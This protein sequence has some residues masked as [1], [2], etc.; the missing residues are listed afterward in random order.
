MNTEEIFINADELPQP[1]S[2]EKLY[3]LV[4]EAHEGSKESMNKLITHNILLVLYEVRNKFRTVNYDK[5]E[6]VSIG[7]FGLIKAVNTFDLSRKFKFSSYAVK[8]IDNE[9]LQFLKKLKRNQ[10]IDSLDE[11]IYRNEN[12]TERKLKDKLSDNND[13][14]EN[15]EKEETNRIIRKVVEKL[16][17]LEREIIMLSFGFYDYKIYTQSEIAHRFNIS[18]SNV[19]RLIKR[20]VKKLGTIIESKGVISLY[21]KQEEVDREEEL[22]EVRK[23]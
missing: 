12:D 19:S 6:L 20:I 3:K 4:Q 15:Y 7:I 13:L 5:K 9:I 18:Q 23:L 17:D 10:S 11:A 1:L 21:F 14:V 22:E 8:L 16:P 2:D